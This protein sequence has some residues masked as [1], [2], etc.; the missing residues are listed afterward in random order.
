MA[1][2]RRL[3]FT[4]L[5]VKTKW[6]ASFNLIRRIQYS[7][8]TI[9]CFP[10]CSETVDNTYSKFYQIK[11]I[12]LAHRGEGITGFEATKVLAHTVAL[13]PTSSV[14]LVSYFLKSKGLS[15]L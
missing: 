12:L 3:F 8:H 2:E 11:M 9:L 14:I 13:Q 4:L 6:S 5:Q 15:N 1:S 7:R 10:T